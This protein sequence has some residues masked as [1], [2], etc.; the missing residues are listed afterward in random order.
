MLMN[1]EMWLQPTFQEYVYRKRGQS[2]IYCQLD[3]AL[4]GTLKAAML[5]WRKLTKT[6]KQWGF[7][8]NP[9]DWCVVNKDIDGS[10]CT[11]VWHVDDLKILE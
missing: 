9:Y 4:Y 10:Q 8:V 2:Y 1:R 3:C 6:L 11:I 5:F 7:T